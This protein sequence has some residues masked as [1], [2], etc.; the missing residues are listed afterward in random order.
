MTALE[1]LLAPLFAA[2]LGDVPE[3][4]RMLEV[5][6]WGEPPDGRAGV[7]LADGTRVRWERGE[8]TVAPE[9][10]YVTSPKASR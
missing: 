10:P 1:R 7:N 3:G 9:R 5:T 6:L 4:E 2:G 8:L